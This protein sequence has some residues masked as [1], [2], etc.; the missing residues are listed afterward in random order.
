MEKRIAK[1]AY[2]AAAVGAVWLFV[3]FLLPWTAPVLVAFA[4]AAL[5]EG[6]VRFLMKH[7]W[8]RSAAAAMVTLA[9][10]GVLV[11]LTAKL[12]SLG[13]Q[14][15]ADFAK[16]VPQLMENVSRL[17]GAINERVKYYAAS[18]P[19]SVREYIG[20][21]VDSFGKLIYTLPELISRKALDILAKAAAGSP[22]IFLFIVTAGIGT[23]FFSASFPHTLAFIAAQLPKSAVERLNTVRANL[24][25]SFGG[26]MKAQLI[27]MGMTFFQLVVVFILLKIKGAVE[28]AVITAIIDALPVF[29]TGIVLLP[30]AAYCAVSG[31]MRRGIA[32]M[33]SWAVVNLIRN[34]AQAKLLGD[35]IGLDPIASLLSIYVGF[36]IWGVGGMLIFPIILV[37]LKQLN[38]TGAAELWKRV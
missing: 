5:M 14:T 33:L 37:T 23:Y 10:L 29:G 16:E 34:C 35:Q 19:E 32:L 25:K 18:A 38:D 6:P 7:R 22:T 12:T 36:K 3:R 26:F 1:L 30:W 20:A 15:A 2:I 8:N 21:A 4:A 13:V 24:K 27:L 11:Y 17:A 31:D 28:I 9:V